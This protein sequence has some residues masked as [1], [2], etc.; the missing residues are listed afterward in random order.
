[1]KIYLAHPISGQSADVVYGYYDN[2]VKLLKDSYEILYPMMGKR[3]LRTEIKFKAEGYG[4][5]V[6]TNHAIKERDK[7]MVQESDI[8]FIDF[9]GSTIVSMGCCMELAWADLLGKH[10][11]VVLEKEN[12]HR[13]AFILDS[14]DIV[15]ETY[16]EAIEYLREF[17]LTR[18]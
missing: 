2:A 3:Y 17:K 12:I 9:T 14:A 5:P 4:N 1:M 15:F 13:H 18:G 16:D 11:I 7:W 6:S 10:T 8:V